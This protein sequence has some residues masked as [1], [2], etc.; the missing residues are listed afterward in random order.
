VTASDL[1]LDG[2]SVLVLEDEYILADEARCVLARAGATVIGPFGAACEALAAAELNRLDCA[3]LDVDLGDGPDFEPA[4]ALRR[5]GVP[6]VF[7]TG[8]DMAVVPPDLR[9]ARFVEKPVSMAAI[10][11]VIASACGRPGEALTV[12]AWPARRQ[13][14]F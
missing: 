8:Y 12:P 2:L 9:E 5:R 6:L 4:R 11:D 1:R 10:V 3:L 14:R 7:F 13:A